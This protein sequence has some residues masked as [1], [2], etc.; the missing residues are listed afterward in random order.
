MGRLWP[1]RSA[2]AARSAVK[3][4]ST[5]C[6][7]GMART[8]SSAV[9]RTGSQAFT[10]AASTVIE[11]NTLP[12]VT[13]MSDSTR[14]SGNAAPPGEATFASALRTCSLLT[15]MIA[16]SLLLVLP[17]DLPFAPTP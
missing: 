16:L 8:A 10:A 6:T 5:D 12:S 7:P 15:A 14:A 4:T 13:T 17:L 2:P 1:A 11:K 9:L 3:A